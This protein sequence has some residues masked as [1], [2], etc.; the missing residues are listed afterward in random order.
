MYITIMLM[1]TILL[2]YCEA[3]VKKKVEIINNYLKYING[4][5]VKKA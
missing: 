4:V 5:W 3:G 1:S 2:T